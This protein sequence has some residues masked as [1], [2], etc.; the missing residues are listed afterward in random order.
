MLKRCLL[1]IDLQNDF[2]GQWA[3]G[4]VDAL[5]RNTNRLVSAFRRSGLPVIWI[6]QQ[7]RAD[8]SDASLEMRDRGVP[9][10]IEGTKG[11]QLLDGLDWR[12]AD[13]TIIKTRYS[14]FFKTD[15]E[16]R[17]TE[18][19]A[20]ELVLCGVN[21]HA[22]IRVAAIDAYQRD[23]RVVL[24]EDCIGSYDDEHARVSLDYMNGKI[25]R[26]ATVAEIT[27]ALGPG[28]L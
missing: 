12:P 17:L 18:I 24:A 9:I 4:K 23:F 8:L 7:F 15:L 22:C 11:A 16:Q 13:G 5:V 1:V 26:V 14:A 28:L 2:L 19:G 27:R 20:H 10:V 6:R 21:T 3:A 25:A